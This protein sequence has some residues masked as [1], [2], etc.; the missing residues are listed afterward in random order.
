[1]V[2]AYLTPFMISGMFK[3]TTAAVTLGLEQKRLQLRQ[4]T[5]TSMGDISLRLL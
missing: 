1:M 4:E 2:K 3:F 5:T